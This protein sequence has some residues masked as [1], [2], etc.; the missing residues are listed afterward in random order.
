MIKDFSMRNK[1]V[2]SKDVYIALEKYYGSGWAKNNLII[3]KYIN[4]ENI[5]D[6]KGE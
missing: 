1:F 4:E 3:H 5:T 2:V 6:L